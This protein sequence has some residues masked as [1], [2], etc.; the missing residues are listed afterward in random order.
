MYIADTVINDYTE[1][2]QKRT[3]QLFRKNHRMQKFPFVE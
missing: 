1:M 2:Q 3:K